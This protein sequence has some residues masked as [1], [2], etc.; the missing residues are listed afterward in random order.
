[1]NIQERYDFVVRHAFGGW[2]HVGEPKAHGDG[3][4]FL[5]THEVSTFDF[6]VMTRLVVAAHAVLVRVTVQCGAP[7]ALAVLMYPR[8]SCGEG[9]QMSKRHPSSSMLAKM[10]IDAGMEVV[11]LDKANGPE[12]AI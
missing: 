11:L 1:M 4:K 2:H 6:D 12:G 7:R 5:I 10:A 9:V 8:V 3:I